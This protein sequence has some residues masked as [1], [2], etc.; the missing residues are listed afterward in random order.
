[1]KNFQEYVA[2]EK[3]RGFTDQTAVQRALLLGEEV[4]E[5]FKAMRKSEGLQ[6][7]SNSKVYEVAEE[8]ADVFIFL[9]S[10]AN[11]YGIDL[12]QAFRD[13]EEK[14]KARVWK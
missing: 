4:G 2:L 9:C 10:L 6:V 7:D 1:M 5:L 8:M 14:N 11:R 13:K 12:E 3:E